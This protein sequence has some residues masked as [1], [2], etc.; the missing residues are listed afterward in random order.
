MFICI[1]L[2]VFVVVVGIIVGLLVMY[3]FNLYVIIVGY[4]DIV[5]VNM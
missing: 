4:Y 3:F 5:V 2:F 1:V